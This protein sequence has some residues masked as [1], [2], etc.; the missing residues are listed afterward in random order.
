MLYAHTLTI[1]RIEFTT[2]SDGRVVSNSEQSTNGIAPVTTRYFLNRNR[3]PLVMIKTSTDD[4]NSCF[5][6]NL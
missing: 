2:L 3:L 1:L 4:S 6:R 5:P